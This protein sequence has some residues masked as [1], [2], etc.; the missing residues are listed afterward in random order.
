MVI[1]CILQR[2]ALSCQHWDTLWLKKKKMK[3]KEEKVVHFINS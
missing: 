3:K 1:T 2:L